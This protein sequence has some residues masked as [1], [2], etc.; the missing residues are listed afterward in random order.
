MMPNKTIYV[1]DGDTPIYERAQELA[2]GN[3]AAAIAQALRQ[4]V[5]EADR[6]DS[7]SIAEPDTEAAG[8]GEFEAILV[9]VGKGGAYVQQRFYGRLLGKQRVVNSSTSYRV[10]QTEK[11]RFA[12]YIREGPDWSGDW[13]S[14]GDWG[15]WGGRGAES[16]ARR[17]RDRRRGNWD[18]DW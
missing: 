17:G 16:H 1:A 4:F 5:E 3:L 2:G 14:W 12:V 10:Y 6:G 13:R 11:G 15:N 7:F 18:W 9:R 8:K